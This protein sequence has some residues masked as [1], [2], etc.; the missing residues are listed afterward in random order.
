MDDWRKSLALFLLCETKL[1]TAN[2]QPASSP[3]PDM[4]FSKETP[5]L[6]SRGSSVC[7][8]FD[9]KHVDTFESVYILLVPCPVLGPVLDLVMYLAL[10]PVINSILDPVSGFRLRFG[11]NA[12]LDP[13]RDPVL[14]YFCFEE[15]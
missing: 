10:F 7:T 5:H 4:I 11:S 12:A 15:G 3:K 14:N 1:C 9:L 6:Q 8:N 2:I 13:V